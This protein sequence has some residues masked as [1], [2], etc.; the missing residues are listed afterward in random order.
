MQ[1]SILDQLRYW[2]R[3]GGAYYKLVYWNVGVYLFFGL[4]GIFA[5]LFEFKL[6]YETFMF[7]YMYATTDVVDMLYKPWTIV[8]HMFLHADF[9]HI[10]FNMLWLFIAGRLL[11]NII[12]QRRFLFLYFVSGLFALII[13]T[14]AYNTPLYDNQIT[15]MLGASG[16]VAGVFIAAVTF[17]P[18]LIVRP[19][20]LFNV[21]LLWIG[22]VFVG[23]DLLQLNADDSTA[24]F[25]HLGGALFGFVFATLY[26]NGRDLSTI[27]NIENPFKRRR[28]M[29]VVKNKKSKSNNH[30]KK[31]DEE[32]NA[33]K[34]ERQKRID[35]ILDKIKDSGYD[36]LSKREKE[37][38]FKESK[39]L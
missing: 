29:R 20:G 38:L 35:K 18:N 33:S 32:F 19:F 37:F 25:A 9:F 24:H 3:H 7:K 4:I 30:Q 21:R 1:G 11:E 36:S 15:W 13:Q 14:A 34:A 23:L 22:V 17:S 5:T 26:T 2:Y 16:A 39:N 12:G 10:L 6:D 27:I 31:T 28:K 8:T